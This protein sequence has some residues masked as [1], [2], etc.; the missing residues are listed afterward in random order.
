MRKVRKGRKVGKT[1]EAVVAVEAKGKKEE[2]GDEKRPH[3]PT[4]EDE[5]RLMMMMTTAP[6]VCC[7]QRA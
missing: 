1:T 4:N 2:V 7:R 6:D 5:E 3:C